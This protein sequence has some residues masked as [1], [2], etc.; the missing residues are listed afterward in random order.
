[1]NNLEDRL[2][3]FKVV[4]PSQSYV[5]RI[6]QAMAVRGPSTGLVLALAAALVASIAANVF[7]MITHPRFAVVPEGAEAVQPAMQT[8][9]YE[10]VPGDFSAADTRRVSK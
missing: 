8:I 2:R 5:Q 10:F 1:M 6:Q 9:H 3:Q 4:E 7:F